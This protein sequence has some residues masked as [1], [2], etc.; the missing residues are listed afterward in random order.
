LDG[1]NELNGGLGKLVR[2]EGVIEH[3]L[4]YLNKYQDL[5]LEGFVRFRLKDYLDDLKYAVERAVD[6]YIIE[7]EYNEFIDL[8]KYFVELQEP[9]IELVHV[10]KQENG[11]FEIM[12]KSGNRISNEYLEGYLS[13]MF[14]EQV[15]Y[16]DLLIS[17]LI[18]VAPLR[19]ILHL[20]A[21]DTISTVKKIFGNRVELCLGCEICEKR[22]KE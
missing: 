16:E 17:A 1:G 8:L 11:S 5:N 15:E 3:I 20:S 13:E 12:D 10:I 21:E 18:N 19:I 14:E 2:K 4:N 6:E 22:E 7:K 9:R